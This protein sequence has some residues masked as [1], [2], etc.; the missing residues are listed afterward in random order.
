MHQQAKTTILDFT[1]TTSY[2]F[3]RGV[4]NSQV[5]KCETYVKQ[6]LIT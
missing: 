4:S 2:L 3:S 5:K 1:M 6:L